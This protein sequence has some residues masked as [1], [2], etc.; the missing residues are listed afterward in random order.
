VTHTRILAILVLASALAACSWSTVRVDNF[1]SYT[2]TSDVSVGRIQTRLG[3]FAFRRAG[4]GELGGEARGRIEKTAI[5]S[6]W[7]ASGKVTSDKSR[8]PYTGQVDYEL[9]FHG[10]V[11][12]SS[13]VY[14]DL[15]HV[16]TLFIFPTAVDET[17]LLRVERRD[18]ATGEVTRA[19]ARQRNRT[20]QS[21]IFVPVS[22]WQAAENSRVAARLADSL[23]CQLWV[24]RCEPLPEVQSPP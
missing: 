13:N 2:V 9:T 5:V 22:P 1:P 17:L 24:E 19:H 16:L 18:L 23:F 11:L 14:R 20:L 7:I 3:E 21:L 15:V 12:G 8:P 10:S 4:E 6:R